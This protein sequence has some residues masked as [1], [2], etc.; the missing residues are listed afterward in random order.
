M[1]SRL[2]KNSRGADRTFQSQKRNM[3]IFAVWKIM[4]RMSFAMGAPWRS[5]LVVS[6]EDWVRFTV[7]NNIFFIC[8]VHRLGLYY[9]QIV[10]NVELKWERFLSHILIVLVL[11]LVDSTGLDEP[12]IV[13]YDKEEIYMARKRN[14]LWFPMVHSSHL[15]L[16]SHG[17][18]DKSVRMECNLHHTIRCMLSVSHSRT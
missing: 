17:F 11:F 1:K 13:L 16:S 14:I 9:I 6:R 8:H 4:P 12:L 10:E 2:P 3:P 5:L 7:K 18:G 15:T